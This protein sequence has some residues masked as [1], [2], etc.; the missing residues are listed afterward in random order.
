MSTSSYRY[1]SRYSED[2]ISPYAPENNLNDDVLKSNSISSWCWNGTCILLKWTCSTKRRLMISASILLVL[3]M[4]IRNAGSIFHFVELNSTHM[5]SVQS[6]GYVKEPKWKWQGRQQFLE[7]VR[8]LQSPS[9]SSSSSPSSSRSMFFSKKKKN[10]KV[11]EDWLPQ[12]PLDIP[13]WYETHW[14]V[15]FTCPTIERIVGGANEN[16]PSDVGKW[17]L[18]NADHIKAISEHKAKKK[19]HQN[20]CLIYTSVRPNGLVFEKALLDR[21]HPNGHG[22]DD[23]SSAPCEIH[24]FD[25]TV[26]KEMIQNHTNTSSIH[27]H[28]WGFGAENKDE[29]NTKHNMRSLFGKSNKKKEK[30]QNSRQQQQPQLDGK[31]MITSPSGEPASSL[32]SESSSSSSIELKTF[33]E[34]LDIL[35]HNKNGQTIDL[36][37]LDCAGCEWQTYPGWVKADVSQI[38]LHA[39]GAPPE[40]VNDMFQQLQSQHYVTYHKQP[41]VWNGLIGQ[42]QFYSFLKLK[43]DFFP[44]PSSTA[45]R[46]LRQ[47]FKQ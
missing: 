4:M 35:G 6:Y 5:A 15:D 16:D 21:L 20:K 13:R 39:H 26:P 1:R 44:T 37:V 3:S 46:G 7:S 2:E 38:L 32:G 27:I 41:S 12:T 33:T 36:L 11:D 45:I 10:E 31:M 30:E 29:S 25:P 8:S 28:P 18:C 34:T 23:I 17:Y 42:S 24:V 40:K 14:K 43:K 19:K 22:H 9:L 47:L